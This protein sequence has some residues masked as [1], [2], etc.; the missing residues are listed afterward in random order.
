MTPREE[1]EAI[2]C[3]RCGKSHTI[4]PPFDEDPVAQHFG[5][6]EGVAACTDTPCR[7]G[8]DGA[9]AQA[10]REAMPVNVVRPREGSTE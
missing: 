10:A 1:D 7:H 5:F 3:S 6:V 2:W 4:P 8:W 9:R